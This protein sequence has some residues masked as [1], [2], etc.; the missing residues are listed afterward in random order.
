VQ[1]KLLG[2]YSN[3]PRNI[4]RIIRY[5]C[6]AST[7]QLQKAIVHAL[8]QLNQQTCDLKTLTRSSPAN[9]ELNFEFG[10]AEQDAFNY[11]DKEELDRILRSL[12][13]ETREPLHL[14]DFFCAT[15]YHTTAPNGKRKPLKFDYTLLRFVFHQ[16]I[17]EL[18]IVHERGSQRIPLEDLATFLTNSINNELTRRGQK[19]LILKHLRTL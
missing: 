2:K 17:V 11:L 15:R 13:E 9:C 16:K 12:E 5:A 1:N 14:L 8:Y 4:Q 3:F 10:I 7:K 19:T 6:Q 18:S